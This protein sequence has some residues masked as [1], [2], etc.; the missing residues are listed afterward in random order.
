MTKEV[1]VDGIEN[2]KSI[3]TFES[4][5]FSSKLKP[6]FEGFKKPTEIQRYCWYILKKLKRD[7]V[8]I[9][10]T[11][12]GKTLAFALPILHRIFKDEKHY[13]H[14]SISSSNN[15]I[16]N[17]SQNQITSRIKMLILAPTRELAI[18]INNVI[19][20]AVP[21]L[22]IYGGVDKYEQIKSLKQNISV[23]IGTPG[24]VLDLSSEGHLILSNVEYLVLD[25]A[26]RMLDLGFSQEV[27][28]IISLLPP[29]ESRSTTMFSATWPAA[30]QKMASKYL[31]QDYV[32]IAIGSCTNKRI[33]QHIHVIDE[34]DKNSKLLELLKQ[35]SHQRIIIFA[36]YKKEASRLELFL[37]KNKY[38]S[39][40]SLHGDKPQA[41]RQRV[42]ESFRSGQ[43]DILVATDVA[44]RGLDIPSVHCVINYTF[45]L[46]VEDYIHRI[47]RT[48]RAGNSG[49][50]HTFFT[51]A[52]KMHAGELVNYLTKSGIQVIPEELKAFGM[53][54]K[55]KVH[56]DYGAHFRE[57][58]PDAKSSHTKFSDSE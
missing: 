57:I 20:L 6:L 19:S 42:I 15:N 32:R 8:G 33:E 36:L 35:Y 10:E 11:G 7:L 27:Q 13:H 52:N 29:K 39:C 41:D 37:K 14:H 17:Q 50:S 2:L 58:D 40:D 30:I 1:S 49:I 18:Q 12:S 45:P 34:F 46:T 51:V 54:I 43:L 21:S 55:K 5:N 56:K 24:R 53:T 38:R 26:D 44:S 22:C 25:E 47:G 3:D 16:Q 4:A 23:I 9:A 31:K 28:S 48:G